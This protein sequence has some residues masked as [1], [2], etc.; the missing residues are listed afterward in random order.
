LPAD[1][2]WRI[3]HLPM[4][5]AIG[6]ALAL[7]AGSAGFLVG[8]PDTG[9]GAIAGVLVVTAGFTISTLAIAWAD[10]IRPA[11][12]MPV[13]LSVYLIKYVSIALVL[14]G[15]GA[16]GWAGARPMAYGIAFGAVAMTGV[17]VWWVSRLARR[18][19]PDTP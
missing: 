4:I 17:Q 5:T 8:G 11:L 10:V 3:E 6:V 13:G 1:P 9:L 7:F 18:H 14:L 2:K 19:L 16:S 12:I 15:A